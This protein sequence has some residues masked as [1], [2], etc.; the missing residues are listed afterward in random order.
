MDREGVIVIMK[1][2]GDDLRLQAG[3]EPYKGFSAPTTTPTP[4]DLFDRFLPELSGAE[5]K[6]LL[7]IVRRTFGFKREA[8]AISLSQMLHG[9]RAR[10][11]RTL[12]RGVGLSKKTLLQAINSLEQRRIIFTERRRSV[13]RGDE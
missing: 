5:L 12:D 11:G 13:E 1:K 6:V 7:Y 8:D 2:I 4:D 3:I 9:L 10:D